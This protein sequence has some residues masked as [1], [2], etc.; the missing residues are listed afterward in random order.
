MS[1]GAGGQGLASE[2]WVERRASAAG[3]RSAEETQSTFAGASTGLKRSMCFIR[4]CAA[5]TSCRAFAIRRSSS[6]RLTVCAT[7][8]SVWSPSGTCVLALDSSLVSRRASACHDART[9]AHVAPPATVSTC[10]ATRRRAAGTRLCTASTT[11]FPP[12]LS[13]SLSPTPFALP[14]SL[15][16][17]TAHKSSRTTSRSCAAALAGGRAASSVAPPLLPATKSTAA[18]ASKASPPAAGARHHCALRSITVQFRRRRPASGLTPRP[19][20]DRQYRLELGSK[21]ELSRSAGAC[22]ARGGGRWAAPPGG[23]LACVRRA[24]G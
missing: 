22:R 3:G 24:R 6:A 20:F 14:P 5:S 16:H 11:D 4:F 12:W 17:S 23:G 15:S 13:T 2:Y 18:S 8:S 7:G 19:A 9:H 1:G 10:R 21:R